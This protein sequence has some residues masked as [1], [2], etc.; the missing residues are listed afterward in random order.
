MSVVVRSAVTS[1]DSSRVLKCQHTEVPCGIQ[2][3]YPTQSL[4]TDAVSI[5]PTLANNWWMLT[6]EAAGINI[7]VFDLTQW[8][9]NYQ[10]YALDAGHSIHM[11]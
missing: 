4:Y 7:S 8:G 9:S 10:P 5:S 1:P 2:T 3:Q 6:R 11:I